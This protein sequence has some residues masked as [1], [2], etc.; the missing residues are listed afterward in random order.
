MFLWFVTSCPD[1]QKFLSFSKLSRFSNNFDF[2]SLNSNFSF[3]SYDFVFEILLQR[4]KD[5]RRGCLFLSGKTKHDK[6]CKL[7]YKAEMKILAKRLKFFYDP[8]IE[9]SENQKLEESENRR[10]RESENPRIRESENPNKIRRNH[11]FQN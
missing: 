7:Y 10:I 11:F 5:W 2:V 9:E 8:E 1:Y 4:N 3:F 6:S